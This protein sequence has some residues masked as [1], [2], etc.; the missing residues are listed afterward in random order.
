MKSSVYL[1]DHDDTT[2]SKIER[3]QTIGR[4]QAEVDA[5]PKCDAC[6]FPERYVDSSS[7]D[8][9]PRI[10]DSPHGGTCKTV[11]QLRAQVRTLES[12]VASLSSP[13]PARQPIDRVRGAIKRHLQ[14]L[15]DAL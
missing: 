9:E 13:R 11:L 3:Q 1:K 12:A 14:R 2:T 4:L 15:A 6:G 5:G 7:G 8:V 10:V